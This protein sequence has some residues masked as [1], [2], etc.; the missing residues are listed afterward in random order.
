MAVSLSVARRRLRESAQR[1]YMRV[2][3]LADLDFHLD[4]EP[5]QFKGRASTPPL[6][7]PQNGRV[8]F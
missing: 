3:W 6:N 8:S 7:R 5:R 1:Q 4:L 2:R